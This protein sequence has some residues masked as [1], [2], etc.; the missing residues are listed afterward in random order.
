VE[1]VL[2]EGEEVTVKVLSIDAQG[3]IRLSRKA[4]LERTPEDDKRAAE[5]RERGGD[6][7]DRGGDEGRNRQ[8][9]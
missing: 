2:K 5:A 1:D 7:G 3:K 6:R 8:R 9:G 4:L